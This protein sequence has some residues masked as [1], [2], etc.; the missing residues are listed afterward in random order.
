MLPL[1]TPEDFKREEGSRAFYGSGVLCR[2]TAL[3]TMA[4]MCRRAERRELINS[5]YSHIL[6]DSQ[7]ST[8]SGLAAVKQ[9]NTK[10]NRGYATTGAILCLCARHEMVEPNGAVDLTRGE[11]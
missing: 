7:G 2:T 4:E 8:C 11:K 5:R 10:Y 3:S 1:E 9:A 6:M